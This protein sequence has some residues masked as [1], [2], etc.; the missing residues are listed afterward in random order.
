MSD[1]FLVSPYDDEKIERLRSEAEAN[2][3][4][5]ARRKALRRVRKRRVLPPADPRLYS[6]H[7]M[8]AGPLDGK[9]DWQQF[10][11]DDITLTVTRTADGFRWSVRRRPE[12]PM[13]VVASGTASTMEEAGGAVLAW[14][15]EWW[16]ARDHPQE[17]GE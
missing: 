15:A 8:G 12:V 6:D 2:A 13:E 1:D 5:E 14:C 3:F 17:P 16:A 4:T 10:W 7:G 11:G 9:E